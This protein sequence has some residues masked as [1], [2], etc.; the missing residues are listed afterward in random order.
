MLIH[1][2]WYESQVSGQCVPDNAD[3]PMNQELL[4]PGTLYGM[5]FKE[6][7]HELLS[8]IKKIILNHVRL[9]K[10]DV[11]FDDDSYFRKVIK[12]APDPCKKLEY[13]MATGNLLSPT[14]LDL[15][16]VSGFTV[17][18]DKLNFFR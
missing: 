9:G 4:L 2:Y 11:S 14:G 16:Q 6:N 18:A 13:L 8:G 10:A 3:S 1:E 7:L 17:V 12:M 5:V 15:M